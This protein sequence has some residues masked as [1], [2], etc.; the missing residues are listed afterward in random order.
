MI[1]VDFFK[2]CTRFP[3]CFGPLGFI[4][5]L[6]VFTRIFSCTKRL[7][8]QLQSKDIN[9]AKAVELVGATIET[10]QEFRDKESRWDE[11]VK[12]AREIVELHDIHASHP[13]RRR[14]AP[15]RLANDIKLETTGVRDDDITYEDLRRSIYNRTI[16]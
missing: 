14:V 9:I 11:I 2:D 13:R 12:Y 3:L 16:D 7:L 5:L 10:L 4:L 8:D 1:S 15:Q 6:V